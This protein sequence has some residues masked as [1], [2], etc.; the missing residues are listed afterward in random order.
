MASNGSTKPIFE[1]DEQ[2]YFLVTL[3]IH[4]GTDNGVSN[5]VT[6]II[7]NSLEDIIAFSNQAS[8]QARVILNY[9]IHNKVGDILS[10]TKNWIKREELFE[11]VG[12]SNQTANRRKYLDPLIEIGW[13]S[14]DHPDIK[15]HP[16]QK[17]KITD[18]GLNLLNLIK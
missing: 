16:N 7:F 8:N 4:P 15:T 10:Q 11:N 12:L 13:I 6:D 3:P 14:M 1:T 18:S 5:Q 2:T 9:A 17:Y